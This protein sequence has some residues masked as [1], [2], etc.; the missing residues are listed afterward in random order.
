MPYYLAP[1]ANCMCPPPPEALSQF[2][3]PANSSKAGREPGS[4]KIRLEFHW[5]PD[6]ARR[7]R[8]RPE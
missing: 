3:I 8:T 4:S 7:R 1:V 2:V 6:L 5:I